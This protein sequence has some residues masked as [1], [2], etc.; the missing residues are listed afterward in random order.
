MEDERAGI[1]EGLVGSSHVQERLEGLVSYDEQE[2][3]VNVEVK[4]EKTHRCSSL[5][6][7]SSCFLCARNVPNFS[8]RAWFWWCSML[9]LTASEGRL[10]VLV[11]GLLEGVL[12]RELRERPA[13]NGF[14]VSSLV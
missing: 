13:A 7:C 8:A 4:G 12:T 6:F 9:A 2:S 11:F 10:G 1:D 5:R 3:E 14:C